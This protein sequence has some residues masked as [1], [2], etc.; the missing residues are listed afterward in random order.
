MV[1]ATTVLVEATELA[2]LFNALSLWDKIREKQ[3]DARV[4]ADT[5]APS[6]ISPGGQSRHLKHHNPAG[7]HA[8][9]T[10]QIVDAS[11]EIVHWDETD[12]KAGAVT[13]AKKPS[14]VN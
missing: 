11:G 5:V 9:T 7:A 4:A 14:Q 6:K 8:C 1:R 12:I 2:D 3:L 10:H 13:I